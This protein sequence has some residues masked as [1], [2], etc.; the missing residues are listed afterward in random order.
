MTLAKAE[1]VAIAVPLSGRV[2]LPAK[3]TLAVAIE[4]P[5]VVRNNETEGWLTFPVAIPVPLVCRDARKTRGV[6]PVAIDIVLTEGRVSGVAPPP[7]RKI[8]PKDITLE[9]KLR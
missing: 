8:L 6:C 5:L 7:G 2:I 9:P 3:G 4:V 1:A